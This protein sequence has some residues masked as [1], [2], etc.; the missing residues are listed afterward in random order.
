M[1]LL[2]YVCMPLL[3][4]VAEIDD[5]IRAHSFKEATLVDLSRLAFF[6]FLFSVFCFLFFSSPCQAKYGA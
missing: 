1:L 3:L 2:S 4:S 5:A 6:F